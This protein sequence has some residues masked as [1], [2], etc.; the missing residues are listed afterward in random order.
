MR[1]IGQYLKDDDT[2][3]T[4]RDEYEDKSIT[5]EYHTQYHEASGRTHSPHDL[6][7]NVRLWEQNQEKPKWLRAKRCKAKSCVNWFC[8]HP[9]NIHD[10]VQLGCWANLIDRSKLRLMSP[11][12]SVCRSMMFLGGSGDESG[13][14]RCREC[15]CRNRSEEKTNVQSPFHWRH[16]EYCN[17]QNRNGVMHTRPIDLVTVM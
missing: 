3:Y 11:C 2:R 1:R 14:C 4:T 7:G 10:G 15:H 12:W 13:G 6:F 5:I 16:M 9:N 17:G 8:R